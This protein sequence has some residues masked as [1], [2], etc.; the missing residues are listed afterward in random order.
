MIEPKYCP[1]CGDL[2][3]KC[4]E[5]KQAKDVVADPDDPD[6]ILYVAEDTGCSTEYYSDIEKVVTCKIANHIWFLG[7]V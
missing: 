1:F 3:E 6:N 4:S 5:V 7:V 2:I